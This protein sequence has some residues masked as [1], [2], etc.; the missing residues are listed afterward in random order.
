MVRGRQ[1]TARVMDGSLRAQGHLSS[2][3][4]E[5]TSQTKSEELKPARVDANGMVIE[6]EVLHG[7]KKIIVV[8]GD[9]EVAI[10]MVRKGVSECK[11]SD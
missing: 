10:G 2:N 3:T 9:G 6:Y 11:G 1:S 5:E 7:I 4:N 8:E